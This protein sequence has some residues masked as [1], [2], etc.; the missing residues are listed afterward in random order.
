MTSIL[1]QRCLHSLKNS[2]KGLDAALQIDFCT[3]PRGNT[4]LLEV[5]ELVGGNIMKYCRKVYDFAF[6]ELKPSN[7]VLSLMQIIFVSYRNVKENSI[8]IVFICMYNIVYRQ[9]Q[10]LKTHFIIT[11]ILNPLETKNTLFG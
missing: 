2:V 1:I 8:P 7:C 3:P 5:S 4:D 10:F 9:T 11:S 6:H